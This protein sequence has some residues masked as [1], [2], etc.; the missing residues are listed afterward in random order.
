MNFLIIGGTHGIGGAL[1]NRL[2]AESKNQIWITGRDHLSEIDPKINFQKWEALSPSPLNELPEIIHGLVYCPGNLRLVPF[3]RLTQAQFLED[4]QIHLLGA[5]S[6]LQQVLP[7]LKAGK[8]SVVMVSSLAVG[9]GMPFHASIA[10][11]KG[12]LEGLVRSLAAEWAPHVRVN[13][14]APSLTDTP[15][16]EALLNTAEKREGMAKRHP[17]QKIGNPDH[18]ASL[19]QWLLSHEAEFVTGQ[20]MKL[21]GGLS[22]LKV[23]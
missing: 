18:I 21:D 19:I 2:T 6:I 14:V 13:A 20:V 11:S 9:L 1:V 17:V 8:G 15:L 22:R 7:A 3:H 16:A 12:A 10:V 5:I 4:L 23:G